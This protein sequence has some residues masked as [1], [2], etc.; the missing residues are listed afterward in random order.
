MKDRHGVWEDIQ[1]YYAP[2]D[3]R[4]LNAAALRELA[5]LPVE[6][7]Q[8]ALDSWRQQARGGRLEFR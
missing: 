7:R 8:L 2:D 1:A 6:D 5:A 4:L 3:I